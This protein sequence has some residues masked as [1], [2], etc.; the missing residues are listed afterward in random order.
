MGVISATEEID[1]RE[2][3][4]TQTGDGHII[5][6]NWGHRHDYDDTDIIR[7]TLTLKTGDL[8]LTARR[9]RIRGQSSQTNRD[10]Q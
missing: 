6:T 8:H 1:F 3:V 9:G 4:T 2:T 5:G 7:M 10:K